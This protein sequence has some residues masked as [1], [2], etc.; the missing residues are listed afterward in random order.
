M[1]VGSIQLF[2]NHHQNPKS[3]RRRQAKP[4][5]WKKNLR[6]NKG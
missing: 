3:I 1:L 2:L 5:E 4:S 6:K